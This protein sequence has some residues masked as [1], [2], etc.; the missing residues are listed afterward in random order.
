MSKPVY[1]FLLVKVKKYNNP[2]QYHQKKKKE[3]MIWDLGQVTSSI[4][5]YKIRA[6]DSHGWWS[7]DRNKP[8]QY[9]MGWNG[10]EGHHLY[11]ISLCEIISINI[12]LNNMCNIQK[13]V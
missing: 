2:M 5:T 6:L 8:I 13:H 3:A 4:L 12:I 11:L 9:Y 10:P 1:G 7:K